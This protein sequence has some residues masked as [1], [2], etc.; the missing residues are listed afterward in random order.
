M[1]FEKPPSLDDF[2]E[3]IPEAPKQVT[4]QQ[5]RVRILLAVFGVFIL[6]LGLVNLW[7][8]DI[9][10]PLRGTGTVRGV[11]V[12]A[13]GQPFNG[14]VF[15]EGTALGTKTNADGS[16]E[17]KNIPAGQQL[18]VVADAVS[19]REFPV[20]IRAGQTTNLGTVQFQSTATP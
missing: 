6:L 14:D 11:A 7:K 9:T 5:K 15:V 20:A 16:F 4:P 8:S 10:A 17:L 13:Q 19:G 2:D 3:I 18:I 1:A 12:D